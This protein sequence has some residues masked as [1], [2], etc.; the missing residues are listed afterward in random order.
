M[1]RL[2]NLF[3]VTFGRDD[4]V[5]S[6]KWNIRWTYFT[7]WLVTENFGECFWNHTSSMRQLTVWRNYRE[8]YL[9][10]SASEAGE[11]KMAIELFTLIHS[12]WAKCQSFS[13]SFDILF[14]LLKISA[15]PKLRLNADTL[16][17]IQFPMHVKFELRWSDGNCSFGWVGSA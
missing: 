13:L 3:H 5:A 11:M 17:F 7:H 8:C 2:Q 16:I 9:N 15:C 14:C 12:S 6:C 1:P 10:K 4:E